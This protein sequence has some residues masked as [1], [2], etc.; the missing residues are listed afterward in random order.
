M[1]ITFPNIDPVVLS[2]GD[3]PFKITWYSLSYVCG[4]L[5]A[6]SYIKHLN[7]LNFPNDISIK[8][9]DDLVTSIIIGVVVGGRL[10][11][12]LFYELENNL[13]DP[14]NIFRTWNGGMSFHGG[15]VGVIF[16]TLIHSKIYKISFLRLMDLIACATPIGL[17]LGRIANFINA[18]LYGRVTDVP[19]GVLFPGQKEPRH[20]SQLYESFSEGIVLFMILFVLYP[21]IKQFKGMACGIFLILYA[22]FRSIVENY[23]Q[24]DDHIGFIFGSL[25][26]GQLLSFPMVL[27]GITVILYSL[28]VKSK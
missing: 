14:L 11:Y 24:P 17:F 6:F 4:I 1:A 22:L 21:R 5:L 7:K 13:Q 26:M 27:V 12:V 23:R 9:L 28:R 16:A 3:S 8:I 18:E 20:P 10:G 25:T 15:L 2:F 19:W